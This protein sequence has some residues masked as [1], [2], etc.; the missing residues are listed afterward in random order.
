MAVPAEICNCFILKV[1]VFSLDRTPNMELF[2]VAR[3]TG[4]MV[5]N[6]EQLLSPL[7]HRFLRLA[8][9]LLNDCN[10]VCV[11]DHFWGLLVCKDLLVCSIC[12]V[13]DYLKIYL[14]ECTTQPAV[15]IFVQKHVSEI[16]SY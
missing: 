5:L 4:I 16:K 9:I 6:R 8:V 14:L 10:D 1:S 11:C 3:Q 13:E 2:G 12:N 15:Y 7:Q